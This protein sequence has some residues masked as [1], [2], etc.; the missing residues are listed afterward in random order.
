MKSK[1]RKS[2]GKK[3]SMTLS[4]RDFVKLT[5][6]ARIHNITRPLAAKRL[7]REQLASLHVEKQRLVSKN[8]LGL[9]DSLQIDIFNSTSKTED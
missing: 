5:E 6:Y 1:K 2:K 8:Q 7:I 9:F 3:L 4:E